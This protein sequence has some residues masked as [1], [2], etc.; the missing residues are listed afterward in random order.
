[1]RRLA[2]EVAFDLY[3]FVAITCTNVTLVNRAIRRAFPER[4]L[5]APSTCEWMIRWP[6]GRWFSSGKRNYALF[7]SGDVRNA[8][9]WFYAFRLYFLFFSDDSF[10]RKGRGVRIVA[11]SILLDSK[12]IPQLLVSGSRGHA[13]IHC[14]PHGPGIRSLGS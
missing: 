11:L 2:S 9:P 7:R 13:G 8:L 6:V 10:S 14:P 12:S 1:M 4:F 3:V 5:V